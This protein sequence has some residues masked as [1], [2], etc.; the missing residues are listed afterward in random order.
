ME[1]NKPLETDA[2]E[3]EKDESLDELFEES[4]E[5]TPKEEAGEE[6]V[7]PAEDDFLTK[8]EKITGRK[9]KD[10]EDLEKHYKNLTSYVGKKKEEVTPEAE[11]LPKAPQSEGIAELNEKLTKIEFLGDTPEAKSHFEKFV[12][13]IADGDGVSYAEA[14]ETIK[15]LIAAGE[16]QDKE[17][18]IGVSSKNRTAPIGNPEV[19]RLTKAARANPSLGEELVAELQ[20]AKQLD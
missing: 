16:A 14:W 1:E 20:K 4:P 15:P 2:P 12:K 3:E 17:K 11:T 19:K 6:D 8:V 18:D 5:E 10:E 7:Q 13:P 9:F